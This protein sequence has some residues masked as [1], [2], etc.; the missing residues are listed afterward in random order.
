MY[1]P[2]LKVVV[3]ILA[4]SY[5]LAGA[6]SVL[7]LRQQGQYLIGWTLL[8]AF[9]LFL[10]VSIWRLSRIARTISV[11]FLWVVV[12]GGAAAGL[13]PYYMPELGAAFA[14]PGLQDRP[15][16]LLVPA[17]FGLVALRVLAKNKEEFR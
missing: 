2:T 3:T 17:V 14:Y 10:A 11:T 5:L 16:V 6:A 12:L 1:K 8:A 7:A 13:H 4:L 15:E 9:W